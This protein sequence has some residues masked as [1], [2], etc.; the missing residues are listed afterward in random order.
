MQ[1]SWEERFGAV[2]YELAPGMTRLSVAR[3]P[4]DEDQAL[5][6]AAEIHAWDIVW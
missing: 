3:P 5:A 1:R 4:T 2:I 6:L